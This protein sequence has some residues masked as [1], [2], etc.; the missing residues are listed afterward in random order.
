MMESFLIGA[1]LQG[2]ERQKNGLYGVFFDLTL[3]LFFTR[4]SR[5]VLCTKK[6]YLVSHTTYFGKERK[7]SSVL[8]YFAEGWKESSFACNPTPDFTSLFSFFLRLCLQERNNM[9][10]CGGS[11]RGGR[12]VSGIS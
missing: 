8:F 9:V 3:L 10:Y 11:F 1:A 6:E 4:S 7:I 5:A 2:V 12:G